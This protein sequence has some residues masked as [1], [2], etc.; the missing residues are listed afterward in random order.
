MHQETIV[1]I[2]SILNITQYTAQVNKQKINIIKDRVD[3]MVQ[4]VNNLYNLTTSLATS[5]SYYQLEL[6]I[7]S[8][9]A[10]LWD[11]LSYIKSVSMYIIDNIDAATTGTLSPHILPIA[12]LKQML[13]HIEESLLTTM[14]LAVSSED[15]LHF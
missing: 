14:H 2:L 11:L 6:H 8:V 5:L 7:R 9:L 3:E 10:N 1:Y 13:S 4:D 12:D 15:T